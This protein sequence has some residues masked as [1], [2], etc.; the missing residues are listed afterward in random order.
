MVINVTILWLLP[1]GKHTKNYGKSPFFIGKSTISTGPFSSWQTVFIITRGFYGHHGHHEFLWFQHRWNHRREVQQKNPVPILGSQTGK[2]KQILFT[3]S[4]GGKLQNMY[5]TREILRNMI[6]FRFR[7]FSMFFLDFDEFYGTV[8]N[9]KDMF[10]L[11]FMN[12]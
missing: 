4:S 12:Y 6:S 5:L 2:P 1:S 7:C 9:F 11:F 8:P 10:S 3:I